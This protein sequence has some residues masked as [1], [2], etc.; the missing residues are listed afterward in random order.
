MVG[1]DHPELGEEV[2]A[3]VVP[4]P[5]AS[6]D[7]EAVRDWVAQSL[8]Y[9]KVPAHV[10]MRAEPLPRNAS[11]KVLKRVLTGESDSGFVAE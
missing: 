5:G 1:V 11:G 3:S 6:V 2:K 9:F 7:A 8:A 10:D 4:A